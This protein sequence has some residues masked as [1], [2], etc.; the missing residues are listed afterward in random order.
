MA[1]ADDYRRYAAQCL[2][3]AQRAENPNDRARLVDM[4]HAFKQLALKADASGDS[5]EK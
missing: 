1:R 3:L 4:A 5:Q 2:A